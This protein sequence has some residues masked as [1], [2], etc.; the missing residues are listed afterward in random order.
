MPWRNFKEYAFPHFCLIGL[1]LRKV[2]VENATTIL[3]TPLWQAQPWYP[4]AL[5]MSSHYP[6]FLP[7][8]NKSLRFLRFRRSYVNCPAVVHVKVTLFLLDDSYSKW[9]RSFFAAVI[10]PKDTA[11]AYPIFFESR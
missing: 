10:V 4:K 3:I 8:P 9:L 5:Q 11:F 7:T 1:V 6:V 2:Q